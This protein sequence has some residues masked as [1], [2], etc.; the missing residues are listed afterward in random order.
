MR[1][2][3]W[4]NITV[5]I[6][7]RRKISEI[8]AEIGR[9]LMC[10]LIGRMMMNFQPFSHGQ[11]FSFFLWAERVWSSLRFCWGVKR[12]RVRET[13]KGDFSVVRRR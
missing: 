7:R 8:I 13:T 10:V 6:G 9:N 11:L 3:E 1:G 12:T 4:G 5:S 2:A